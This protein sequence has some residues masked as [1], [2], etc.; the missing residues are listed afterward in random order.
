MLCTEQNVCYHKHVPN[1][2]FVITN[3]S[4]GT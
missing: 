3:I 4:F 1:E 2:L